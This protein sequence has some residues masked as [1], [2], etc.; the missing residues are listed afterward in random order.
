MSDGGK[1]CGRKG[2]SWSCSGKR[3]MRSNHSLRNPFLGSI[4]LTALNTASWSLFVSLFTAC[5]P[6]T[7][8][9][10]PCG[11]GTV[12][13]SLFSPEVSVYNN[14]QSHI[15]PHKL[16]FYDASLCVSLVKC[17]LFF[18]PFFQVCTRL[19]QK[20]VTF[21]VRS[22]I[23]SIKVSGVSVLSFRAVRKTVAYRFS[24]LCSELRAKV[25]TFLDAPLNRLIL[26]SRI[27]FS[28]DRK[29]P[30][31]VRRSHKAILS[32]WTLFNPLYLSVR[33]FE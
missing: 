27:R 31:I 5:I 24:G 7:L 30:Y 11:V 19:H 13:L 18:R 29:D 21:Q 16:R 4:P 22:F 28:L 14:L 20:C 33:T 12:F 8:P 17:L 2:R 25:C 6:S 10:T 15:S 9:D 23:L 26:V 3:C 1:I 32:L